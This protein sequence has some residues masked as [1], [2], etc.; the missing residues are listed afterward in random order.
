MADL[1]NEIQ[2]AMKTRS[3]DKLQLRVERAACWLLG[4]SGTI[5]DGKYYKRNLTYKPARYLEKG[6]RTP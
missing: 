2:I 4:D 5:L 6:T 3:T 1:A